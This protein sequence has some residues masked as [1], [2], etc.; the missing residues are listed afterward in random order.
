MPDNFV[1]L[2]E[3]PYYKSLLED[4]CD[5]SS[6]LTNWEIEFI[7]SLCAWDGC[8]SVLQA[9]KLEEMYKRMCS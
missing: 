2:S 8:F 1:V 5:V 9:N 3:M 6:G 7:D 4:F